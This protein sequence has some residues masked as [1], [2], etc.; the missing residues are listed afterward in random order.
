MATTQKKRLLSIK[1]PLGDDFL[2]LNRVSINEA[3]SELFTCEVELLHEE[4]EESYEPTDV[5]VTS[6]LGKPATVSI[7]HRDDTSRTL[8]GII[9]SFSKGSRSTRF[10]YYHATIVPHHWLLTQNFQSRIFQQKTVEDILREVLDGFEVSIEIQGEFKPRNY[11]VQYRESDFDFISRLM[12]EEGFF[13]YFEHKDGKHKMVIANTSPSHQDAPSKHIIP[14]FIKTDRED[15]FITSIR[16]LWIDYRLQSG[17]VIFRDNHFQIPTNNLEVQQPSRHSVGD[18]QTLEIYDFPGGFARKYDGIDRTGGENPSGMDGLFPDKQRTIENTMNALDSQ[19]MILK[20]YSDCPSLTAGHRFSLVKHPNSDLNTQYIV[21]QISHEAEQNPKYVTDDEIEEPYSANFTCIPHGA[22]AVPFHPPRKTPK[23]VMKGS[24]TAVVVGPSGEEIFTDK[25]GRVKIQFHWHR[26]GKYDADSSCWVR[27]AKDL[28]GKKYGSMYI[29]RIGQEVIVDFLEGDP[30]QPIITGSVY[31]PETMPHYDLPEFKTLT[32]IK[33]RTSPDDGQGFNELRFEDKQGKEQVFIHSQKRMD[34]RVKQSS[35]ATYGGNRHQ[36]IGVRSDNKPGGN[37]AITVG[38]NYDLHVK[39]ANYIGIDDKLN[40]T[41]G[42]DVVEDYQGK[43]QTVVSNSV[44]VNARKITLE[45]SQS[46]TLKVGS[47][48]IV[49]DMMGI[50]IK[51]PMVK[52]N[53]GG[54]AQ[55]TGPAIVDAPLDAESADTGEPGYLDRPR[56]GGG[57]KGRKRRTLNGQH[58]PD[59]TRNEDGSYNVGK[60]IKVEGSEDFQRKAL[61]DV[62]E[63]YNTPTGKKLMDR[64]NNGRHETTIKESPTDPVTGKQSVGYASKDNSDDAKDPSKGTGTTI[65]YDTDGTTVNDQNGDPID[66]PSKEVLAHEMIHGLHNSEGTNAGKDPD[67]NDPT[68]SNL[69]ES[70]TIGL[71][72]HEDDE[73]TENRILREWGLDYQRTDHR[74]G[75]V[76]DE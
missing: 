51:G 74:G 18:N 76:R 59:V 21:T 11:C 50:T 65:F 6:L 41:V 27:V 1:T 28:A 42:A 47:S 36:R 39:E 64:I 57:R 52:I 12:E 70:Q 8:S 16:D 73:I 30:D 44:E 3:I 25:Y 17:K 23:P 55:G 71:H 43:Q 13:Y 62:S 33:T 19:Y 9:N 56:S 69:E 32:Y 58:A 15:D 48:F 22:G 7:N 63:I 2:L 35:Y 75:F 72:D 31:N 67:P 5:D 60:N 68:G 29:P 14:Y 61:N 24:Q 34:T 40:E 45:G 26:E 37:L 49:V 10:S 46:V 20:G 54:A 38:A 66:I 53:S 4:N